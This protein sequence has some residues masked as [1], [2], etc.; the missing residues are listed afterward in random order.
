MPTEIDAR[1]SAA[2]A[3]SGSVFPL[4]SRLRPISLQGAADD[5]EGANL[6]LTFFGQQPQRLADARLFIVPCIEFSRGRKPQGSV[7]MRRGQS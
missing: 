5:Y 4:L 7:A 6:S 1:R 3:Q 2:R